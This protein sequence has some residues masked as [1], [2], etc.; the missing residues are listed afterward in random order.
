[1]VEF[2]DE[3]SDEVWCKLNARPEDLRTALLKIA[4]EKIYA[5]QTKEFNTAGEV[6]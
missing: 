6:S 1:M 4:A 3:G 5:E 2:T